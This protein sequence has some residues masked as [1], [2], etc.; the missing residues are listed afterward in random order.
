MGLAPVQKRPCVFSTKI[1]TAQHV[2]PSNSPLFN[3]LFI[4][5]LFQESSNRE[6][7]PVISGEMVMVEYQQMLGVKPHIELADPVS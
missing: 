4:C 2:S 7:S 3:F 1:L 5:F 6:K